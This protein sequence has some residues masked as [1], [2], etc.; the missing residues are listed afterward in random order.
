MI[1]IYMVNLFH[2]ESVF[3]RGTDPG[4]LDGVASEHGSAMVGVS[5]IGTNATSFNFDQD[6]TFTDFR[7]PHITVKLTFWMIYLLGSG[8][9]RFQ[10][11]MDTLALS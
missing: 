7:A 4:R 2:F 11:A 6:V 1:N 8:H 3:N 5:V 9:F 10:L